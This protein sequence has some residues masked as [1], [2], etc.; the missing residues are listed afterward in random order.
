MDGGGWAEYHEAQQALEASERDRQELI[1]LLTTSRDALHEL[2]C[3]D[4][5]FY[6]RTCPGL[7]ESIEAHLRKED[8]LHK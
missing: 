5:D 7:I 1:W 3:Y 8:C 6:D 4:G 2:K